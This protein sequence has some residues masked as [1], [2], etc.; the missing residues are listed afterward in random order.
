MQEKVHQDLPCARGNTSRCNKCQVHPDAACHIH[1]DAAVRHLDVE[2]ALPIQPVVDLQHSGLCG[3]QHGLKYF[4][5][6]CSSSPVEFVRAC[7]RACHVVETG[8]HEAGVRGHCR[9]GDLAAGD[10]RD[11]EG[12]GHEEPGGDP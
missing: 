1:L 7:V 11:L 3:C 4:S 2:Q 5:G 8:L 9:Y 10:R 12:E 6:V